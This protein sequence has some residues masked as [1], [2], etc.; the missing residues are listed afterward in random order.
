MHTTHHSVRRLA[1]GIAA[2]AGYVD[3][4]GFM[5]MKG[6]FVSFM[7]GNSTRLSVEVGTL[8][9]AGWVPAAIIAGFVAGVAAGE[10][11]GMSFGAGARRTRWVLLLVSALLFLAMVVFA[12]SPAVGMFLAA[13][14]M[15]TSNA[16]LAVTTRLPVGLTYMTGMLVAIGRQV[17][18]RLHRQPSN[19]S[20]YL[21]HWLA[22][23]V[24]GT[25]GA[26]AELRMGIDGLWLAIMW[27][28]ML[29]LMVPKA[30][31]Q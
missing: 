17:A 18:R 5:A 7:S 30:L 16:A 25:L 26:A 28:A 29:A 20:P 15:G 4:T 12:K 27:L 3:A 22:L 11:L 9:P 14:A 21:L 23:I 6:Y 2:A 10:G 1:C 13:G 19:V 24:G 8:D 31:D